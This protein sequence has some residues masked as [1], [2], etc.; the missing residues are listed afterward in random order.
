MTAAATAGAGTRLTARFDDGAARRAALGLIVLA[1]DE[2]IEADVRRLLPDPAV[3][4]HHS[5]VPSAPEVTTE[6]LATMAE[7]LPAAAGLLPGSAGFDAIGYACTSGATV[8]GPE[9]VAALVHGTQPGVPVT[10]PLSA[11][12]AAC[13]ALGVRQ[14]GLVSP[15]VAP[16]SDALVRALDARGIAVTAF[17]SFEEAEERRVARIAP[18]A[19]GEALIA[20]GGGD[21]DAVFASCTNLRALDVAADVEAALG[22]PVLASNSVLAWH[23]ARLAGLDDPLPAAGV[24]GIRPLGSAE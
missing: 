10:E 18:A 20:V 11:L 6:T 12:T 21:C 17:G 19:I 15:Y 22:K 3:R 16:V 8:L 23:L 24:L 1:V 5:R 13:R 9:R 14:L 2:V 4:L 7:T